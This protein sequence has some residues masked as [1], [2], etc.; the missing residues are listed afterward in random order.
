MQ[1]R[2]SKLVIL[3]GS[4]FSYSAGLPLARGINDY[5]TRDNILKLL[6]FTSGEWKWY[7][8]AND[9]ERSNGRIGYNA[10]TY[11]F[12]LNELKDAFTSVY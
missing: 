3:L 6:Q 9:A 7:D 2:M 12:I 4:G 11:G 10:Y 5:F 1:H 8:R